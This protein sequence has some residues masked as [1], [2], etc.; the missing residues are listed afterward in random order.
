MSYH[1]IPV[2]KTS[3][4]IVLKENVK[5]HVC[6]DG[7]NSNTQRILLT[8]KKARKDRRLG[9]RGALQTSTRRS[10]GKATPSM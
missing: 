10:I 6:A 2:L 8:G 5:R 9:V 3:S 4:G 1:V 7:N